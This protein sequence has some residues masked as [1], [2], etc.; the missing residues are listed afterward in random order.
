M[1]CGA[2]CNSQVSASKMTLHRRL[3]EKITE[4]RVGDL[5]GELKSF[6]SAEEIKLIENATYNLH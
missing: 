2:C 6:V 4:I 5:M 3:L 1:G